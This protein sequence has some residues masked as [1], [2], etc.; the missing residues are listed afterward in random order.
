MESPR[1]IE[2]HRTG[3]VPLIPPI[4]FCVIGPELAGKTT[5]AQ[6]LSKR[7]NLTLFSMGETFREAQKEDSELGRKCR[8]L[9]QRGGY[10]DRELFNEVFKWG[11]KDNDKYRNGFIIEGAPRTVEQFEDMPGL[12]H[13]V[14][15]GEIPIKMVFLTLPSSQAERRQEKRGQ[16]LDDEQ[17]STR[18][19]SHYKDLDEKI[20]IAKRYSEVVVVSTV[21]RSS[22]GN[23]SGD[24][25]VQKINEEIV[26]ALNIDRTQIRSF[27]ESSLTN[28]KREILDLGK[29]GISDI[30]HDIATLPRNERFDATLAYIKNIQDTLEGTHYIGAELQELLMI[31]T[32]LQ[33]LYAENI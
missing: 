24:K 14:A 6:I 17:L 9:Q 29:I 7:T 2:Q 30:G 19:A 11:I 27:W 10:A 15:G 31:Q 20:R 28:P 32:Y 18:M 5:Q 23:I 21:E 25:S 22:D 26:S 1:P 3:E 8:E 33:R 12:I 4:V 13:G 16:R